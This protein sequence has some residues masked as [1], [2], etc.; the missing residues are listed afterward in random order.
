MYLYSTL[1]FILNCDSHS[2]L[3][4]STGH[5]DIN[6]RFAISVTLNKLSFEALTREII[7]F[8]C[9]ELNLPV[10]QDYAGSRVDGEEEDEVGARHLLAGAGAN[11][12]RLASSPLLLHP[13]FASSRGPDLVHEITSLLP[14]RLP[15][16]STPSPLMR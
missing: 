4:G 2:G 3:G 7:H 13:R 14:R 10:P 15:R 6:N 16:C 11:L 9:S 1:E 8:V 12:V 5:C